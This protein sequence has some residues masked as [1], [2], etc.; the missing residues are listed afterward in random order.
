MKKPVKMVYG[1]VYP[2]M[3]KGELIKIPSEKAGEKRI[4]TNLDLQ[5]ELTQFLELQTNTHYCELVRE[6]RIKRLTKE[7]KV[8]LTDKEKKE[9]EGDRGDR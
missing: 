9:Q 4:V 1:P 3:E 6:G 5:Q 2:V 7:G 8:I